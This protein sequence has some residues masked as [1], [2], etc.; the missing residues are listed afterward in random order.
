VYDRTHEGRELTFEASGGLIN[1]SLVMQDR[2]TDSYWAIMRGE[3]VQGELAGA[4]LKEI[5]QNRKMRW[6]EWRQLHPGT[7]VLSV[8]GKEDSE[9]NYGEYFASQQGFRE[10]SAVDSRLP[11]KA[12]IFA[13]RLN[14]QPYAVPY[15]S[16]RGGKT[17]QLANT[18]LFFYRS[19]GDGLHDSTRAFIGPAGNCKFEPGQGDFVGEECPRPLVGFDTFWYNWSLNNPDTRLLD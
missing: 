19:P 13:F 12:P 2:E 18:E 9:E 8:D 1:A 5:A 11:T 16:M 15:Q 7:L 6:G 17:Y 3:S 10:L 4:P 14:E